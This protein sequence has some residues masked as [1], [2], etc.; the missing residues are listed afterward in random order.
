MCVYR[1]GTYYLYHTRATCSYLVLK[2]ALGETGGFFQNLVPAGVSIAEITMHK[3]P[4]PASCTSLH[5]VI[6]YGSS[7][8]KT[9][10][11]T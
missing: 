10:I 11:F 7:L 3:P 8:V 1:C 5:P 4:P 9:S 6:K 2:T